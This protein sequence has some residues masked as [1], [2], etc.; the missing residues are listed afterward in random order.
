MKIL[1]SE[2]TIAG[3]LILV[4]VILF[5]RTINN[6]FYWE[7]EIFVK[8]NPHIRYLRNI[9]IFFNPGYINV[10][11]AGFGQRYR[12]LRSLSFALDYKLWGGAVWGY[13]LSNLF[14]HTGV[15]LLVYFMMKQ[16]SVEI[17][18]AFFAALLFA[19]HPI[20]IESV[21]Y[22]KNRTDIMCAM[23]YIAAVIFF[24][25]FVKT[26]KV[27]YYMISIFAGIGAFLSK[28]MALTLPVAIT[29]SWFLLLKQKSG[30]NIWAIGIY[31]ILLG[32]YILF[33][34][35]V[36]GGFYAPYPYGVAEQAGL[37]FNTFAKYIQLLILP[38]KLCLDWDI[39]LK[40]YVDWTS[41]ALLIVFIGAVIF[42]YKK[43]V[44]ISYFGLMT[45]LTLLPVANIVFLSGRHF[46]EQRLYIP[47]VWFAGFLTLGIG[48][49]WKNRQTAMSILLAITVLF[50]LRTILRLNDWRNETTLWTKTV[51]QSPNSFRAWNNLA[52]VLSRSG[53]YPEAIN[54]AKRSTE[55][56]PNFVDAYNT[57]GSSYYLLGLYNKSIENFEKAVELSVGRNPTSLMNLATLYSVVGKNE[58]ALEIYQKAAKI[59]PWSDVIFYNMALT[60]EKLK[61]TDETR[62]ALKEA[63]AL[64]PDN[65]SAKRKLLL[66]IKD[67]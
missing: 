19:V 56:N 28:E 38:L 2:I 33:K 16:L 52:V 9:P 17:I 62:N 11:E 53:K 55:I 63:L 61:R 29:V 26:K 41:I 25:R 1:D 46:A 42:S 44:L 10:Y 18:S 65:E 49:V 4:T 22:L 66:M 54:A 48:E 7:D 57:L 58:K 64:N 39:P 47:S 34:K 14:L 45:I 36:M 20:H 67:E 40:G 8:D 23:F 24:I 32:I 43:N 27:I 21:V 3:L 59:A 15:V 50:S 30:K 35:F 13:H 60:L 6:N 31:Y 12:P 51:K 37:I 5:V